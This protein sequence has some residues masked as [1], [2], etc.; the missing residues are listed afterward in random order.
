VEPQVLHGRD[1]IIEPDLTNAA[2]FLVA[3]VI[4]GGRVRMYWPS[5]TTQPGGDILGILQR[6]GANVEH[7]LKSNSVVVSSSG[8]LNGCDLD[9]H[10]AS[11]LTPVVAGLA[12]FATGTT[13]IMGVGHIRGHETDRIAAIVST[14]R[15]V[16]LTAEESA[17]GLVIVGSQH[18][19]PTITQPARDI[20]LGTYADHRI[21][22]LGALLGLRI[23]GINLVD[24]ATTAKTMP[25][26]PQRWT[27][28]VFDR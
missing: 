28:M 22:H 17:T 18:A 1:E 3:G 14:L 8:S 11:E 24:I 5:N 25:D 19:A 7:E 13:R 21:A 23:R 10:S 16:G 15:A 2:A 9:L 12:A 20:N 26:F 4:T 6:F 27:N